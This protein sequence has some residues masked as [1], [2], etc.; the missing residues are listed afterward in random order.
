MYNERD[1]WG[2]SGAWF[3]VRCEVNPSIRVWSHLI[4]WGVVATIVGRVQHA[5]REATI[6]G[7]VVGKLGASCMKSNGKFLPFKATGPKYHGVLSCAFSASCCRHDP[8]SR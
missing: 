1:S 5:W 7:S 6:L 3:E 4:R 8:P 2:W